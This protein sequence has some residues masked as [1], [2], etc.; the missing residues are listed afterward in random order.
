MEDGYQKLVDGYQKLENDYQK[1]V[2]G[3]QKLADGWKITLS[4]KLSSSPY[5]IHL[6]PITL[7]LEDMADFFHALKFLYLQ[8][9]INKICSEL[10]TFA[11]ESPTGCINL[12][13]E[14]LNYMNKNHAA[15]DSLYV[16]PV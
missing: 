14:V 11:V 1:L 9:Y 3:Y 12:P 6:Q 7:F 13:E 15:S 8:E 4:F 2:D 10:T 16:L 5:H